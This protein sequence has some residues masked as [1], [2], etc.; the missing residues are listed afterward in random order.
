MQKQNIKANFRLRVGYA[1]INL[2]MKKKYRTF[3]LK[4]IEERDIDK[5]K[6]VVQHNIFL[7]GDI[8]YDNI[9]NNIYVYRVTADIIPFASHPTMQEILKEYSIL[10]ERKIVNQL[11]RIREWQEKY[12]LRISMHTSHF[13]ILTS[14]R[15][16]VVQK[17]VQ[18][19]KAQAAFLNYINGRNLI[20]HL[21]GAY[22]D[23]E[24]SLERFKLNVE[25]YKAE[26]DLERLTIENDDKTY[27]SED[28]VSVCREL[29]LKWVYD[30]HHERCKPSAHTP[31][32][33][34][35]KSYKPDKYHLSSGI[36]QQI[37][38]P[39]ADYITYEDMEAFIK[40]LKEAGIREADVVLEAK[41]KNLAIEPILEPLEDG[42]WILKD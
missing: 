23:K 38:P 17:S 40:Q 39:H 7:L 4:T 12:N 14:P 6:E 36:D 16:E 3:R 27:T 42:Y 5:I 28:V 18:E 30:Y 8:I 9:K 31:I 33:D 1:C 11:A 29:G 34:I 2:G 10:T 20:L 15:E 35:L 19:L 41:Q 21:G 26:L 22:G 32:I 24:T 25:K 13:V 37:K